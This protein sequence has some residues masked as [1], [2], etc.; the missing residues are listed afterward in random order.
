M[1][2]TKQL[3]TLALARYES[4]RSIELVSKDKTTVLEQIKNEIKEL[5]P[6]SSEDVCLR[7][8]SRFRVLESLPQ[9]FQ[10]RIIH[11][12]DEDFILAGIRFRNLEIDKP[13]VAVWSSSS[14]ISVETIAECI[15]KE[16]AV[17]KPHFL[18]IRFPVS[19][20]GQF[21]D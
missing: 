15:K 2:T 7:R 8:H 12:D 9:D 14:R 19:I 18:Q 20:L 16:F 17:F 6:L 13:F 1:L 4:L 21:K 10:E 11:L 3:E 5:Y